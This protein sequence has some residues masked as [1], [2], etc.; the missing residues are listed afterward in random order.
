[1][2]I[3]VFMSWSVPVGLGIYWRLGAV[4][5]IAQTLI[6]EAVAARSRHNDR[7]N[8]GDGSTLAAIRRSAHHQGSKKKEK[9][10]SEKPLWRK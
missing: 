5:S 6:R 2:V 10:S 4:I 1:M 7:K 3:M 9:K 8:T